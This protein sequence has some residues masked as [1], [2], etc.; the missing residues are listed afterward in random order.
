MRKDCDGTSM[1]EGAGL[2]KRGLDRG[3]GLPAYG[4]QQIVICTRTCTGCAYLVKP[5]S[6][7][8]DVGGETMFLLLTPSTAG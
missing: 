6:K 8:H 7:G 4:G 3:R 1:D 5:P 2:R